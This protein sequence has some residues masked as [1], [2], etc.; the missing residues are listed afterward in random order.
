MKVSNT[1]KALKNEN[2]VAIVILALTMLVLLLSAGLAIDAGYAYFVKKQLQ[3]AAD[4]GALA[5][6]GLLYPNSST[7]PLS[8]LTPDWTSAGSIAP[9]FIKQNKAA[10]SY[11]TDADIVSVNTGYW[12][13]NHIPPDI[14]PSSTAPKFKCSK[15]GSI[16]TP[17]TATSVCGSNEV[18]LQQDVP[19][20]QV[21][22]QRSGL[23][24][25]FTKILGWETF[26]PS[27]TAVA[28]RGYPLSAKLS[29]PFAVS[30]CMADYYSAHPSPEIIQIPGTYSHVANCNTGNWTPFTLDGNS[31]SLIKRLLNGTT[32]SQ[33]VSIGDNIH[34]QPGTETNLYGEVEKAYIGQTVLVPAVASPLTSDKQFDAPITGFFEFKITAVNKNGSH[35]YISGQ[36][37]PY[38]GDPEASRLGGAQGN[39][40]TP[41]M[42]IK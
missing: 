41:P 9:T 22:V 30:Q 6:A 34:I 26:S 27:A 36:F 8:Q 31:D 29:F 12:N 42:L 17:S 1:F 21:T 19:A 33:G 23:P 14:Q 5:G 11:L 16:C 15:S 32:P 3:N 4:S 25:Y 28:A 38:Q 13:L 7:T 40:V 20:V 2:G 37:I 39:T 24:T 35:S 10:G 18:C